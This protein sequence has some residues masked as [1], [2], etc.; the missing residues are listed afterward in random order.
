MYIL[1]VKKGSFFVLKCAGAYYSSMR[2]A[3]SF[4]L[5]L[6]SFKNLSP[7]FFS[8]AYYVIALGGS[9]LHSSREAI[10]WYM[11]HWTLFTGRCNHHW[12]IVAS[13]EPW[14][15]MLGTIFDGFWCQPSTTSLLKKYFPKNMRIVITAA[16][17][18]FFLMRIVR[19]AF[20]PFFCFAQTSR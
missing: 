15:E 14:T 11:I 5:G 1:L 17:G 12:N 9:R 16:R 20:E 4:I 13:A 18:V 19:I 3:F 7:V 8:G 6:I 2:G 10:V